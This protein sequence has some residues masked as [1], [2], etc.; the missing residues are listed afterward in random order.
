[1]RLRV[2]PEEIV[3]SGRVG[4]VIRV[5][6]FGAVADTES[7]QSPCR[8]R[9]KVGDDIVEWGCG[10]RERERE[11]RQGRTIS[12]RKGVGKGAL[13][14]WAPQWSRLSRRWLGPDGSSREG[15]RG[16]GRP[17]GGK[18]SEQSWA[19]GPNRE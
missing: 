1:M 17:C 18:G 11:R 6:G 9:T 8:A 16:V 10:I 13:H 5:T 7:E 15:E 4:I 2:G 12:R 3:I 14:S 19:F